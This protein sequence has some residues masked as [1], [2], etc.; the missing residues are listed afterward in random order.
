MQK[1]VV[2]Q[3]T[4]QAAWNPSVGGFKC[5]DKGLYIYQLCFIRIRIGAIKTYCGDHFALY[6]NVKSFLGTP[7]TNIML[8]VHYTSINKFKKKKN[9]FRISDWKGGGNK[10]SDE[11]KE[12][13]LL[14]FRPP[15]KQTL[16]G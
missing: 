3:K 10:T 5:E 1:E 7:Q 14:V 8:H 11:C 4:V 16:L 12:L 13:P 6:T 9:G 15:T 2:D